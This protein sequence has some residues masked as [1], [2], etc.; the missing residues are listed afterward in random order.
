MKKYIKQINLILS[1]MIIFYSLSSCI[2]KKGEN[3]NKIQVDNIHRGSGKFDKD[4]LY[5]SDSNFNT[6]V[7]N[8]MAKQDILNVGVKFLGKFNFNPYF[9]E[10]KSDYYVIDAIW[11]PL[12][13]VG[14][15][16]EFYPNILKQLPTVSEDKKTYLFSLK[17]NLLWEDGTKLTTKDIDFTYKFLMDGDYRGSFDRETL[18]L[19]NWRDYNSGTSNTIEGIEIIDDYNFRVNVENPSIQTIGLLNIYPLSYI[20][21]GQYY[22]QGKANDIVEKNLKPFGNGV[23][24]FF[25]YEDDYLILKT[26]DYY[27][28]DKSDISTLTFKKVDEKSYIN[29]LI[30]G[31]IDIAYDILPNNENIE[32]ASNAQFLNGYMFDTYDYGS[33]GINHSNELL[34]DI[35]IRKA[36]NVCIDKNQIVK[37][38]SDKNFNIIDAPIDGAFQKFFYDKD[39][40]KND[41]NKNEAV[42]ILNEHGWVKNKSGILEKDGKALQFNI[43]VQENSSIC[44]DIF[45]IIENN[46][47]NIGISLI[48]EYVNIND[49]SDVSARKHNYDLFLVDD[50]FTYGSNWYK[51]FYTSGVNNYFSYSN[52]SLD[53]LL[54]NIDTNFDIEA[55]RNFY[56]E[57]YE[58]LRE[59][60]PVIPLFQRKKFDAYN[61][62]I[63]GINSTNVFK[64]F[65]YDEIILRK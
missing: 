9:V 11:E 57:A 7:N 62:R 41:F 32:E 18:N 52:Q 4:T 61:G 33:I 21:Y 19:K 48:K 45:P 17:E 16:G 3:G 28:K 20:Y 58:I 2:G 51:S 34:K 22:Y 35:S 44:Q 43:L 55:N 59:D 8:A 1:I 14:Y 26:N 25:A 29:N 53:E 6:Y 56:L 27:Y 39:N 65:Y 38:I 46:L 63:F 40:M 13:K 60:L 36:I 31:N 15:D 64:T 30:S 24:K 49:F 23:F 47:K 50:E 54:T 10:S 42:R 5:I 37:N 12:M